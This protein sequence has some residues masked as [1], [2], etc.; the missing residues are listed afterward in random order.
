MFI[1]QINSCNLLTIN[2]CTFTSSR[3]SK[4]RKCAA[5]YFFKQ[6]KHS[7]DRVLMLGTNSFLA[8]KKMEI[9]FSSTAADVITDKIPKPV[10]HHSFRCNP[11][12]LSVLKVKGLCRLMPTLSLSM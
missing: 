2:E 5:I 7:A 6:N 4:D 11:L 12:F 8:K 9:L 10:T 3:K 1:M